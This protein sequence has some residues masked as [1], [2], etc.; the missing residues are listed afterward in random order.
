MN[1]LSMDIYYHFL[2]FKLIDILSKKFHINIRPHPM[3]TETDWSDVFDSP[4]ISLSTEKVFYHWIEKQDLIISTFS[5]AN[6]DAYI[7]KKPHIS[8]INMIPKSIMNFKAHNR[9][10]WNETL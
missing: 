2:F 4:N 10:Y 5:S 9:F 6:I 8:L 3:D 7:F 1:I